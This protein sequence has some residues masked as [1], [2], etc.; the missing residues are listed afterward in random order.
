MV[1]G[2]DYIKD[3]TGVVFKP[4]RNYNRIIS[5]A[6]SITEIL[7]S[8]GLGKK[9]VGVTNYCD[10]PI[11]AKNLPKIGGFINPNIEKII[12]LTPDLIIGTTD[13]NSKEIISKL[14]KLKQT[15]LI[16]NL[17]NIKDINRTIKLIGDITGR[18]KEAGQQ[19]E[20][21][22]SAIKEIKNKTKDLSNPKVFYI[23]GLYPLITVS[24]GSYVDDLIATVGGINIAKNSYIRYP[25]YPIETLIENNPDI[26][27]ITE[28]TKNDKIIYKEFMAK[29]KKY[30]NENKIKI[31][32]SDLVNRPGPRIVEGLKV[33]AKIIHPEIF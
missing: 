32:D 6:P 5:L 7:F 26:I 27:I 2:K 13:G 29:F 9:V 22:E 18:E 19:I 8:L 16:F 24:S 33:M 20:S 30:F 25:K 3:D 15:V 4:D 10:Y 23:V 28:M 11:I 21:I 17:S 12:S 1:L 14:R 31:I